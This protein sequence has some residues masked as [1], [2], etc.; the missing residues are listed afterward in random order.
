MKTSKIGL[1]R[2]GPSGLYVCQAWAPGLSV[3]GHAEG[4][5]SF[6]EKKRHKSSEATP[7]EACAGTDGNTTLMYGV[8]W[9]FA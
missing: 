5:G 3:L 6:S 8:Q 2:P 7:A 9:N 1:D 4:T